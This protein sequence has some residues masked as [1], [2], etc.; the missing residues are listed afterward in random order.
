MQLEGDEEFNEW[1]LELGK[2]HAKN[3]HPVIN[4]RIKRIKLIRS[5]IEELEFI[6]SLSASI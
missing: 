5:R 1:S 2:S 3:G 6:Q 4:V